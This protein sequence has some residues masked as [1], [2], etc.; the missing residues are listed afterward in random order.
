MEEAVPIASEEDGRVE[1]DVDESSG[2]G[3]IAGFT[4]PLDTEKNNSEINY[5]Q[6]K[7]V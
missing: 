4:L 1:S 5:Q 2:V 7:K 3:S 6:H